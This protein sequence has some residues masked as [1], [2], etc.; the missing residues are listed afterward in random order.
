MTTA[1]GGDLPL[2]IDSLA[3]PGGGLLGMTSCPGRRDGGGDRDL[4]ADLQAIHQWGA[5][6]VVSLLE[7]SEFDLLGVPDLAAQASRRFR[8]LWLPI[9]DGGIPD[10]AFEARWRSVGPE[11]SA[12]LAAGERVLIHCRAGLGRSGLVAARLLVESGLAPAAAIR[13]MRAARTGTIETQA[14]EQ[15]LLRLF[16]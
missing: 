13:A 6:T 15:Y 1:R 14:Q 12:R 11:L 2:R 4:A 5:T 7:Q 10:A 3:V 8:W 9:P 16:S